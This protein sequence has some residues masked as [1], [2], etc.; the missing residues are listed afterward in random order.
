MIK[1]E[2]AK[3]V[4]LGFSFYTLSNYK[5][6]KVIYNTCCCSFFIAKLFRKT[7]IIYKRE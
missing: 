3:K 7:Q 5:A 4:L 1:N 6:K 2:F